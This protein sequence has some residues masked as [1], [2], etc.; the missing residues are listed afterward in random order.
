M[1]WGRPLQVFVVFAIFASTGAR[2]GNVHTYATSSY[3]VD[4]LYAYSYNWLVSGYP[5]M[6][7]ESIIWGADMHNAGS[8]SFYALYEADLETD[9]H[10][11]GAAY[12]WKVKRY[13]DWPNRVLGTFQVGQ[14]SSTAE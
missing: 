2:A 10:S 13:V 6:P 5:P 7:Y 14:G 12:T 1:R 3:P 4:R 11:V 9:L 8:Q